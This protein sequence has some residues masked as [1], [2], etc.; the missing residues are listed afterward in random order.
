MSA[1]I[2][3]HRSPIDLGRRLEKQLLKLLKRAMVFGVLPAVCSGCTALPAQTTE[4]LVGQR[5]ISWAEALIELDFD[6]A[7]AYMTP[8]YQASPRADRFR[9]DFSGARFWRSVTLHSVDC[10][11]SQAPLRCD[12]TIIISLI[13][14]LGLPTEMPSPYD[15]TWVS[16]DGQW[17]LYFE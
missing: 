16:L 10:G 7:L 1:P 13:A 9:A 5:A 8:G 2:V 12:V 17:Y 4:D 3:S 6:E 11:K 14:P 15:M